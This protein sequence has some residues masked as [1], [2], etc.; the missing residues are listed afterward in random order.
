MQLDTGFT[1]AVLSNYDEGAP[2]VSQKIEALLARL[3]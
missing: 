1:V 3:Q 2:I